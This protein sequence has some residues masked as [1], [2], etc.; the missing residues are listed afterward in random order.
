[1]PPI[2]ARAAFDVDAFQTPAVL[3]QLLFVIPLERL[4]ISLAIEAK[5][6]AES[7]RPGDGKLKIRWPGPEHPHGFVA[8]D[9]QPRGG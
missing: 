5:R 1:V 7:L 9:E 4:E 8:A 6:S 2:T 3:D